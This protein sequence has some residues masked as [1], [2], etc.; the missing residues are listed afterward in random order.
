MRTAPVLAAQTLK[1]STSLQKS[2]AKRP[3]LT[4]FTMNFGTMTQARPS[5]PVVL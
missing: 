5:S 1:F 3:I 2:N 4:D